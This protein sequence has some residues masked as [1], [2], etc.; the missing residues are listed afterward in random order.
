[1]LRLAG[2]ALSARMLILLA[3]VGAF[4]L[5]LLAMPVETMVR[6]W[7]LIAYCV[8]VVLPLIGLEVRKR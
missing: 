2:Y 1:M 8:L 7:V 6:L 3:L 5:A 4:V